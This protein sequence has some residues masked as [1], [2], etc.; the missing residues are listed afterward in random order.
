MADGEQEKRVSPSEFMRRLRPELYS[1]TS[2]R[3]AYLL[4]AATLEYCL[5][6]IADPGIEH[7]YGSPLCIGGRPA[8]FSAADAQRFHESSIAR[9]PARK[10]AG[11]R[12]N[13]RLL[14]RGDPLVVG[15]C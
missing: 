11:F 4:D 8:Q 7:V 2:D 14:E 1:D 5:D 3:T 12:I 13:R 15:S 9:K 6:T 10:E